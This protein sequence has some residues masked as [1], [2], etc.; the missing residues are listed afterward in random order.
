M[1]SKIEELE[2]EN[3]KFEEKYEKC[4]TKRRAEF[5]QNCKRMRRNHEQYR[6]IERLEEKI[7]LGKEQR[8]AAYR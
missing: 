3:K 6:L 8:D 1:K 7:R 2:I 5:V 4:N